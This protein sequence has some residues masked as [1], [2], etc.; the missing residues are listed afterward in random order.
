MDIEQL[1]AQV[2]LSHPTMSSAEVRAE[3]ERVQGVLESIKFEEAAR[4]QFEAQQAEEAAQQAKVAQQ[5]QEA[6]NDASNIVRASHPQW[7]EDSV[8][9]E[10][11]RL[12]AENES[13][14]AAM[15]LR[16]AIG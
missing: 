4:A 11:Q 7:G 1:R 5:R 13:A 10:A 8:A 12:V 16:D 2:A 14:L 15:A 9:M 6:L 3:A